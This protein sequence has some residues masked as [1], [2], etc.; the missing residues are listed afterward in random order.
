MYKKARLRNEGGGMQPGKPKAVTKS[1]AKELAD[2]T[3]VCENCGTRTERTIK[4][5]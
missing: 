2:I 3:Y 1:V 5:D 4:D